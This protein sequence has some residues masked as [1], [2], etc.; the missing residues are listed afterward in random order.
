MIAYDVTLF[1]CQSRS[2]IFPGIL[3]FVLFRPRDMQEYIFMLSI[4]LEWTVNS[5]C[6]Y[7]ISN[8]WRE[9]FKYNRVISL[10]NRQRQIYSRKYLGQPYCLQRR[11]FG[12]GISHSFRPVNCRF[13]R[14][15]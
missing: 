10:L 8:W 5:I 3:I 9:M 1:M 2:A 12:V 11:A 14:S 13:D 6:D 15:Q 7:Q 4:A